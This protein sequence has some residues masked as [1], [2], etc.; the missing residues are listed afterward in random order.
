MTHPQPEVHRM[1]ELV[2]PIATVSFSAVATAEFLADHPGRGDRRARAWQLSPRCGSGSGARRF[3]RSGAGRRPRHPSCGQRAQ[4][5]ALY[6][7]LR[8]L[9][10]PEEPVARLW[11]AAN[12]LREHRGD[13]HNAVLVAHGIGG[14]EAHVLMALALPMRAAEFSRLHH[15]PEA[16]LHRRAGG[17]GVRRARRGRVRRADRGAGA[18]RRRSLRS[19]PPD[20]W[21]AVTSVGYRLGGGRHGGRR[22]WRE[23]RPG[24][25]G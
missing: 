8:A 25:W 18:D 6:T 4:G 17:T 5:R 11:H 3:P 24:T 16:R 21:E 22:R 1:A 2:E 19:V 15:L 7:G 9:D 13:G 20:G 14:T 12:L 23:W 10:V